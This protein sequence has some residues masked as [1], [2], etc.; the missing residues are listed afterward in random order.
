MR[1]V[2]LASSSATALSAFHNSGSVTATTTVEI[3]AMKTIGT[4]VVSIPHDAPKIT[5]FAIFSIF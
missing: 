1:R 4:T 3:V 2:L 5:H